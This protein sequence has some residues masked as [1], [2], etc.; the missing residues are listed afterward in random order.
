MMD[1]MDRVTVRNPWK[2]SRRRNNG[3]VDR[4]ETA[5]ATIKRS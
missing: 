2:K 3:M 1:V 5:R 4:T